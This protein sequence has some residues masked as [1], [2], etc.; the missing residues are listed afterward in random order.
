VNQPV[1]HDE[2]DL[3]Q[4]AGRIIPDP[5]LD[6]GQDDWPMNVEEV[7]DGLGSGSVSGRS[8]GPTQ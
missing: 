7:D 8:E 3:E 2:G 5:W 1:E 6:P 4:Y